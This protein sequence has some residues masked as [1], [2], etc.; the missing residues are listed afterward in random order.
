MGL[1]YVRSISHNDCPILTQVEAHFHS[2]SQ[3]MSQNLTPR[4]ETDLNEGL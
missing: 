1:V 4:R 3:Q 2:F